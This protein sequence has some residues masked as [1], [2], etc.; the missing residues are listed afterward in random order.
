MPA[1][2][3]CKKCN[4]SYSQSEFTNSRFCVDCGTYLSPQIYVKP[5][6]PKGKAPAIKKIEIKKD[7]INVETLFH[8][9]KNDV[10]QPYSTVPGM[11]VHK[12]I[13]RRKE[14]YRKYQKVFHPNNLHD[15]AQIKRDFREWLLFK[16]NMSWTQLHRMGNSAL[17][18]PEKV[19]NLLSILQDEQIPLSNRF[20]RGLNAPDYVYGIG[21]AIMTGLLHTFDPEKNGVVNS[22][23]RKTLEILRREPITIYRAET[24][25][26]KYVKINK[27][28][29]NL[30]DELRTDLVYVDGFMWYVSLNYS[31]I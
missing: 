30:A 3:Y 21:E 11:S 7:D 19:A 12:W 2:Y 10:V 23:T 13:T 6:K 18:Q 22:R 16:N 17:K 29:H 20:D 26:G 1:E 9:F 24:K 31:F 14:A 25:G 28:L 8:L 5:Q 27:E 4:R 15:T